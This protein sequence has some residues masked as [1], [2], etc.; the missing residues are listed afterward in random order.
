ME[1][2]ESFSRTGKSYQVAKMVKKDNP[3]DK[4]IQAGIMSTIT[5]RIKD[6]NNRAFKKFFLILKSEQI[7]TPVNKTITIETKTANPS[8]EKDVVLKIL[9]WIEI[10]LIENLFPN[11][12]IEK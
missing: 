9:C 6:A 10:S 4:I 12:E 2:K 7:I 8:N 11:P 3:T 5:N 1:L